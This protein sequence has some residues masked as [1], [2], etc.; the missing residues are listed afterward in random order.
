MRAVVAEAIAAGDIPEQDPD[1]ATALV[2]G[3]VL[4]PVT[5]AAYGRLPRTMAPL[6]ERLVNAAWA[7][8]TEGT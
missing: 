6:C 3:V 5:F 2:F 4:E 1:L 8:L 7:V